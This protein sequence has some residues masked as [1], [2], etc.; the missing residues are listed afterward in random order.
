MVLERFGEACCDAC[1]LLGMDR[2]AKVLTNGP[3]LSECLKGRG[4]RTT[5]APLDNLLELL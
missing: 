1:P 2:S 4:P 3:R 5:Y